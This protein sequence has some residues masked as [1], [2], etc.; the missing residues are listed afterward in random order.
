MTETTNG[1]VRAD[2]AFDGRID[3][4]KFLKGIMDGGENMKG[5]TY[6][7]DRCEELFRQ[8]VQAKN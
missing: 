1:T 3:V 5:A 2:Y 6:R 7:K 8:G 4:K